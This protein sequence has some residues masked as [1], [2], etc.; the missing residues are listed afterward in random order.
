[1]WDEIKK[2][3][4]AM[5][6]RGKDYV[7]DSAAIEQILASP[8]PELA[9]QALRAYVSAL[10]SEQD[11]LCFK[12][13]VGHQLMLAQ[14]TQVNSNSGWGVSTEDRIAFAEAHMLAGEPTPGMQSQQRIQALAYMYQLSDQF[15][16]EAQ[17]VRAQPPAPAPGA[18]T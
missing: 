5:W 18:G 15:W 3:A 12:G 17:A 8:S 4:G 13:T 14:Q 2:A 10:A 16:A 6:E 1:M 11:F 7:R 9:V